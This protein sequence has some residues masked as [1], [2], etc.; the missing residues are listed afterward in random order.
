[1]DPSNSNQSLTK[2]IN[3]KTENDPSIIY[4]IY[5]SV[6]H[7]QAIYFTKSYDV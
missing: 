2:S 3:S 4:H 1:M 6:N 7:I 5:V